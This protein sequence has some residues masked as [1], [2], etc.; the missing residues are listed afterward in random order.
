MGLAG[1]SEQIHSGGIGPA[2]VK[3]IKYEVALPES[4]ARLNTRLRYTTNSDRRQ[5]SFLIS[6]ILPLLLC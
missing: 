3:H 2:N 5:G 6:I 1:S 4:A